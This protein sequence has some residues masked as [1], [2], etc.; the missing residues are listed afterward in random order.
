VREPAA[1]R[2]PLLRVPKIAFLQRLAHAQDRRHLVSEHRP[3][4]VAH[5]AIVLAEQLPSLGVPDD[6]VPDLERLQHEGRDLA[7]EGALLLRVHVLG[8][9][10]VREAVAHDQR[11]DR[12]QRGERRADDDLDTIRIV[13]IQQ[14]RELLDGLDRLEVRLVHL[15]VRRDDRSSRAHPASSR[16]SIPGSERPSRNSSEAPPPVDR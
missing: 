6:D 5:E 11:L 7:G 10:P 1:A 13:P 8:P 16:T 9:E 15:P 4:L 2:D 14:V 12:P 3:H